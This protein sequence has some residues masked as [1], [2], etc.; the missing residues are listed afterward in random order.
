MKKVQ[1]KR[2]NHLDVVANPR[3]HMKPFN[4]CCNI[5]R[6][7]PETRYDMRIPPFITSLTN[8]P[9]NNKEGPDL[10]FR[11]QDTAR[12]DRAPTLRSGVHKVKSHT[13]QMGRSK[14]GRGPLQWYLEDEIALAREII[15]NE[16][17]EKRRREIKK[18]R[19]LLKAKKHGKRKKSKIRKSNAAEGVKHAVRSPSHHRS[20]SR[21]RSSARAHKS[22]SV[23][24]SQSNV[25][26]DDHEEAIEKVEE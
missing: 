6:Q 17:E 3:E 15:A 19:D 1:L 22:S 2:T 5:S 7:D 16:K 11:L 18:R 26:N 14:R 10:K 12:Q 25:G 21:H 13:H 20:S 24:K 4:F 9:P 23:Q 8:I